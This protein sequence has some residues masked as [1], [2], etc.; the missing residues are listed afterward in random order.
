MVFQNYFLLLNHAQLMIFSLLWFGI[1]Q[2]T[3]VK[4]VIVAKLQYFKFS[5]ICLKKR[6]NSKTIPMINQLMSNQL[7][8][9]QRLHVQLMWKSH[10]ILLCQNLLRGVLDLNNR[11]WFGGENLLF[12]DLIPKKQRKIAPFQHV[13][14]NWPF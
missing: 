12:F 2:I 14:Q 10:I 9:Q 7:M 1:F 5:V 8:M 11:I 13:M 6:L 4:G 3:I